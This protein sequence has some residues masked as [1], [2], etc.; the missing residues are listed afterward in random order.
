MNRPTIDQLIRAL[1]YGTTYDRELTADALELHA[2]ESPER[3]A[4]LWQAVARNIAA[5]IPDGVETFA[6]VTAA[7]GL[8]VKTN[9]A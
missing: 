2:A 5:G 3:Q 7:H 9:A 1:R 6:R 4:E 8:E